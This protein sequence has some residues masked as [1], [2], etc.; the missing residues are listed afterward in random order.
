MRRRTGRIRLR[1]A[2]MLNEVLA[3][4]LAELPGHRFY[5]EDLRLQTERFSPSLCCW[6]AY[7]SGPRV[8]M[9]NVCLHVACWDAMTDCVR[10]GVA[11]SHDSR[12]LPTWFEIHAKCP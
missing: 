9:S 4:Y 2:E 11:V 7:S 5:A 1:L 6:D 8:W 10:F 12:D 3:P